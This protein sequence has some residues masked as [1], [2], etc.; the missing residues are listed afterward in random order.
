MIVKLT[1]FI[2]TLAVISLPFFLLQ[3]YLPIE[4]LASCQSIISITFP[5]GLINLKTILKSRVQEVFSLTSAK[6]LTLVFSMVSL[7]HF[8]ILLVIT[9][10]IRL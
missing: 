7:A 10:L 8:Q 4:A 1:N 2:P 6:Y 9:C 5:I 3:P